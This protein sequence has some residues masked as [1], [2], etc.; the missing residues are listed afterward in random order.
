[1]CNFE[2]NAKDEFL[3][4]TKK[5]NVI[6]ARIAINPKNCDD[7]TDNEYIVLK[8]GY[9]EDDYNFFLKMLDVEYDSG[10]G[11]QE[12]FGIILCEDGVWLERYDYDGS[13]HWVEY[14]YPEIPCEC[15]KG[16]EE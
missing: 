9:S 4:V 11:R 8:V 7:I 16:D 2:T 12:L 10:F 1:M 13:E 14:K 15:I 3:E 5:L 6:Y